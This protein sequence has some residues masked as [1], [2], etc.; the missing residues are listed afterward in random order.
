MYP[1]FNNALFIGPQNDFGGI[2][3]VLQSYEKN[4]QPFN[5]IATYPSDN[6]ESKF[7]FFLKSIFKLTQ[8]LFQAKEIKIIHLHTASKGSFYRKSIVCI[9][10]K[11]FGKK[12]VFHM[13]G[14]LF[15]Q[16]Y[17]DAGILKYYI[18][19]ILKLGDVVICLSNEWLDFYSNE[20][21]LTNVIVLGNPIESY[22]CSNVPTNTD[23]IHLLFLG[24]ICDDKGIFDLIDFLKDNIYFQENKIKLT[25][26]GIGEIERL[27]KVI[28]NPV[29]KN[30]IKF[31]GWVK[32]EAKQKIICACDIFILPS[33][34]EGLPVSILESMAMGKPIIATNVG[35]IPSIVQN[36]YNGWLFAPG[37]FNQLNQIFKEI[38]SDRKILQQYHVNSLTAAKIFAPEVVF[39]KLNNVYTS[40][41][42]IES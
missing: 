31:L 34:F 22:T 4:I 24:K 32:D 23:C 11:I 25:I 29:L 33:Y 27:E 6:N 10:G 16:F 42:K 21:G 30:N 1:I 40:L 5:F 28:E 20:M 19:A 38:F 18:K 35:G 13:H 39:A 26:A 8:Y 37:K 36:N 14:G 41:I 7:I 9:I 12:I 17:Y 3:A 15:N 2:G